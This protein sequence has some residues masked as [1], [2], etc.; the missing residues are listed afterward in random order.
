M[1]VKDEGINVRLMLKL[2]RAVIEV[3]HEILVIYDE[4]E[5]DT[6]AVVRAHREEHPHVR[7]VHNGLGRGVAN[8]IRSGISAAQGDAVLIFAVDETGPV[9]AIHEML[10]LMDHGCD[11]VSCTRY[12]RGGRRLGGSVMGGLLSRVANGLFRWLTGSALT[13]STTGIKMVRRS[14]FEHITL[15]ATSRSWAVA[16]ELAIKAQLAG[17]KVGEVPIVSIDRLF[18]GKSSFSIGQWCWE[19]LRW[20]VLGLTRLRRSP[21]RQ[22]VAV[23]IQETYEMV[24]SS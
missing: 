10:T 13:D 4:P 9:L 23:T 1:P 7:L 20:F 8:A 19:Y 24:P 14:V 12:A 17:L 15:E 11:L 18:G 3:P 21:R 22:R 5:D 2:L 16:F 6:I